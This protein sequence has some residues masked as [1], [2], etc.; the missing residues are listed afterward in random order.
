VATLRAA[1]TAVHEG[2]ALRYG[3]KEGERFAMEIEFKI[4]ED[5]A[6]SIKQARSWVFN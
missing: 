4:T 2:F 6:L 1:L 5:E 3:V